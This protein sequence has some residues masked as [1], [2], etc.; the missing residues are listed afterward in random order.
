MRRLI[1]DVE[2]NGLLDAATTIHVLVVQDIDTGELI[3][4]NPTT[5]MKEGLDALRSAD[6]VIA[7]NGIAFDFP[8]LRKICGMEIEEDRQFD[9]LILS[10]LCYPDIFPLDM[11]RWPSLKDYKLTGS[12]SLKAWGIRLGD[13][14]GDYAGG[15]E[16]WSQ[17]MEDYCVQDVAVTKRLYDHLMAQKPDPRAIKLEHEV[18][19]LANRIETNGW[20]FDMKAAASLYADLSAERE[21]VRQQLVEAFGS[22]VVPGEEF[23]PKTSNK[24]LGTTKGDTFS[25]IEILTFNP[26]SRHHIADRLIA[27]YNWQPK[28][29]TDN[30]APKVDE[31]TIGELDYPEA[32]LITRYLMLEKRI[33]QLAEG[34]QAWM[35]LQRNGKIHG[36]YITLGT[37]TSRMTHRSPN[38]S[39]VPSVKKEFGKECRALFGVPKGWKQVGADLSGIEI[40][41]FAHA[42]AHYDN[43]AYANE[44]INGDIHTLNQKAMGLQTR[45]QAKTTLYAMLYG[46]GLEKLGKV[47]GGSIG[48]GKRIRDSFMRSVPAYKKLVD[49]IT[50]VVEGRMQKRKNSEGKLENVSGSAWLKGLDGRIMP[51]RSSHSALNVCLQGYG[52]VIAKAWFTGIEKDLLAMGLKHGWG[53][54]FVVLGLIHD[55]IQIA[56]REGLEEQVGQV[57][58][59]VIKKVQQHYDFRCQLDAEYK[60][61]NNWADCH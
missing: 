7:H 10:R 38:I 51:I 42:L 55:E 28:V 39:Q 14:K 49:N 35:L 3:V 16:A 41:C 4:C 6:V 8:I 59:D 30:G 12:H 11:S 33:A 61:G 44:V 54:D 46:A 36:R 27:K 45:D 32:K 37:P 9:T 2:T 21:K 34:D 23:T 24:R 47:V 52:A 26:S 25:R 29:Y 5:G 22:W 43:G 13:H 31:K 56:C 57:T 53:G 19:Q 48:H 15:W 18:A 17:E 40:R 60:I 1:L 50:K 58:L 20:P